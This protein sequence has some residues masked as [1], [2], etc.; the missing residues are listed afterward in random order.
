MALH[1]I[2]LARI[3]VDGDVL[4]IGCGAIGLL[5]VQLARLAGAKRIF[6]S[7]QHAW[8]LDLARTYG[9]ML[10]WMLV[11]P[12]SW[13]YVRE[14]TGQRGVDVAIELAWVK[15][16]ASQ[17]VEAARNGGRVVI[18]GI[19]AEDLLTCVPSSARRKGLSI[20]MSRRMKHTYAAA[21]DLVVRGKVTLEA[22]ATHRFG[23]DQ[24]PGSL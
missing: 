21:I 18:V 13:P 17:C 7:D 10:R 23:L 4:I 3:K 20:K 8:R 1:A 12:T 24:S 2:N 14:A 9:A 11:R 22:L 5:I 15:D 16:T 6:V 19:P